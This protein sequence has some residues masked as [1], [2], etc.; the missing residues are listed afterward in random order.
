MAQKAQAIAKTYNS[1]A[2]QTAADN[3]RSPFWDWAATPVHF[4]AI[5]KAP[6]IQISTPSGVKTV[7]NPLYSYKFLNN[8]EIN[9]WFPSDYLG[10]QKQTLRY[11]DQAT[12]K[13]NDDF[14]DRAVAEDPTTGS[15]VGTLVGAVGFTNIY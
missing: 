14:D 7:S 1:A 3:L 10:T 13:S 5:L 8:P 9:N 15:V 6:T 11:P 12:N 4:P 2:W